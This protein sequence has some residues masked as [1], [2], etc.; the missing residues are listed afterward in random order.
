MTQIADMVAVAMQNAQPLPG[1]Q[2][3]F[4]NWQGRTITPKPD[5]ASMAADAAEEMSFAMSETVEKKLKD[6]KGKKGAKG[7]ALEKAQMYL[8]K[9]QEPQALEKFLSLLAQLRK[10]GEDP[11]KAAAKL[12]KDPALQLGALRYMRDQLAQDGERNGLYKKVL[13]ALAELEHIHGP[14]L[15]AA[16]NMGTDAA[17]HSDLAAPGELRSFYREA[18]HNY[19]DFHQVWQDIEARFPQT[20]FLKAVAFLLAAAGSDLAASGPSMSRF[21][22]KRVVDDL[23]QLQVLAGVH[24]RL[25]SL[26]K[27]TKA[28]SLGSNARVVLGKLL[29]L[30]QESW[31]RPEKVDALVDPLVPYSL[32]EQITFLQG[33]V[34]LTR[35]LPDRIF[36]SL[37][38]RRKLLD[39]MAEA[40]DMK[41]EREE[42]LA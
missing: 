39:V 5:A 16:V 29:A 4:G 31:P 24:E 17:V 37:E 23:T 10:Q 9:L 22:L 15:K 14:A 1:A 11:G 32:Q 6:R 28:T 12:F 33:L 21:Q 20:D 42:E 25:D 34:G 38:S 13:G 19:R 36:E 18:V 30:V 7:N 8:Q 40:L 41:I 35:D 27:N 3:I 2:D 26:L